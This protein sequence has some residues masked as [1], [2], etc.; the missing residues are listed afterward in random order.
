MRKISDICF[1][2]SDGMKFRLSANGMKITALEGADAPV[3]ELFSEKNAAGDGNIVTGKRIGARTLTLKAKALSA[4]HN[5]A[6]RA[7]LSAFFNPVFTFDAEISYDESVKTARECHLKALAIPTGNLHEP[8]TLDAALFCA[9]GYLDG[10]G[11]HGQDINSVS[12]CFGFPYVSLVQGGM[13]YG[14][15]N[16]S[17]TISVNNT[18]DG[19]TW[20]KAVFTVDGSDSVE[21]PALLCNGYA[22]RVM[23]TLFPGDRLEIDA[24]RYMIRLN[25]QNALHLLDKDSLLGKMCMELGANT[26]GFDADTHDNQL[27]VRISYALRYNGL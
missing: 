11:M 5:A 4:A 19:K 26:I 15:L 1:V 8:L 22:S 24:E 23:T 13:N 25:G 12:G 7:L 10:G 14:I 2:R 3:V 9:N 16:F 17:K 6:L 21:N 27:C 18:G 20:I